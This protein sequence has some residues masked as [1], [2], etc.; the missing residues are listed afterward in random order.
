MSRS[1]FSS[2]VLLWMA[3]HASGADLAPEFLAQTEAVAA[4]VKAIDA[5]W[6][7]ALGRLAAQQGATKSQVLLLRATLN[8]AIQGKPVSIEVILLNGKPFAGKAWAPQLNAAMHRLAPAEMTFSG[9]ASSGKLG[10]TAS[11]VFVPDHKAPFEGKPLNGRLTI[12]AVVSSGEVT[13]SFSAAGDM[14]KTSGGLKGTLRAAPA[15]WTPPSDL[16][17]PDVSKLDPYELYAAGVRLEAEALDKFGQLR[18]FEAVG[19]GGDLAEAL[20]SLPMQLPERPAFAS[21]SSKGPTAGKPPKGPSIDD[22]DGAGLGLDDDANKAAPAQKKT[23]PAD[24]SKDPNANAR[25]A[26]L[27]DIRR[28]LGLLRAAAEDH[29]RSEGKAEVATGSAVFED[30]HFGPW[31]GWE[32]LPA[33]DG[34]PQAIPADAGA[35]GPQHWPYVN[36]WHYLGPLPRRPIVV[37]TPCLPEILPC[38]DATYGEISPNI[39]QKAYVGPGTLRWTPREVVEKGNGMWRPPQWVSQKKGFNEAHNGIPDST[40]YA[41]AHLYSAADVELWAAAAVDDEGMLW[42]NNRLA[43]VWRS[44]AD[45][46][47]EDRTKVFKLRFRKGLNVLVVRADKIDHDTGF[48]VRIC[49]RGKPRDKATAMA[50]IASLEKAV[51]QVVNVPRNVRGWRGNWNGEFPGTKPVTAWDLEKEINVLWQTPLPK[52]CA[53]AVVTGDRVI[54][55]YEKNGVVCLDRKTGNVLWDREMNILELTDKALYEQSKQKRAVWTKAWDE[56]VGLGRTWKAQIESI[57]KQK[58]MDDSQAQEE[59]KRLHKEYRGLFN[60]WWQFVHTNGKCL[61]RSGWRDWWGL[62]YATPVTDGRHVWIKCAAG[63]TAC[64]DLDGNRKWMVRTDYPEGGEELCSSPVLTGNPYDGTGRLIMEIPAAKREHWEGTPLKMIGLDAMTGEKVWEVPR[65]CNPQS[66]SSPIPVRLTDGKEEMDVVITGGGGYSELR[67]NEPS[68]F[69]YEGGTVVRALDGKVLIQSMG[70][71]PGWGSPTRVRNKVFHISPDLATGHEMIMVNRDV[72]GARR[73]WTRRLAEFDAG[74]VYYDGLLH[75]Q[76]GGQWFCG[77]F[78]YDAETGSEVPRQVNVEWGF[79]GGRAYCPPAVSDGLVFMADH[80]T[81]LGKTFPYANLT[82]VQTGPRGRIIAKNSLPES[83]SAGPVFDGDMSFYRSEPAMVCVGYT[84]E[85]GKAFEAEQNARWVLSDF[86]AEPP[87]KAAAKKMEALKSP[88]WDRLPLQVI[89]AKIKEPMATIGPCPLS[90]ADELLRE[91][92]GPEKAPLWDGREVKVGGATVKATAVDGR[93][94]KMHK[95][96]EELRGKTNVAQYFFGI[97]RNPRDWTVRAHIA[98]PAAEIWLGGQPVANQDRVEL[99]RGDYP[100]LIRVK[101]GEKAPDNLSLNMHFVDSTGFAD[102]AGWHADVKRNKDIL[103]RVIRLKPDSDL[104]RKA[105][106]I[107]AAGE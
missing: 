60:D 41:A 77:Y 4:D 42:V 45:P 46:K 82:V 86:A 2:A 80:G 28:H 92:G 24:I 53:H 72:V 63:V 95:T 57:K 107:L 91:L 18:V 59:L 66:S 97:L 54:A 100:L 40:V 68:D 20:R 6:Y 50:R 103:E 29:V 78:M 47:S 88:P 22:L 81:A 49:L 35:D 93:F 84:G 12:S 62:M 39:R 15:P 25:L 21:A 55:L 36:Q 105:K 79:N 30:P 48:S 90:A 14:G 102:V 99:R 37:S 64:F 94:V 9:D 58:N 87:S 27:R 33:L 73:M 106:A 1:G 38:E 19:R 104:A 7:A 31:Y 85:E 65:S 34:H 11:V 96:F 89:D 3:L 101:I 52:G 71:V 74:L 26:T 61:P 67:E 83:F 76:S 43:A 10:G 98:M 5:A 8:G 16:P 70:T 32:P 44:S 56:I 17:V 75:G 69:R 51:D 23:P 13:G